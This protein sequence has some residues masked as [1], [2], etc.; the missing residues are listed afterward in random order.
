M[1][2]EVIKSLFRKLMLHMHTG[3]WLCSHVF[4]DHLMVGLQDGVPS[5]WTSG[6]QVSSVHIAIS[7][8]LL[9]PSTHTIAYFVT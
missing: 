2:H 9:K 1:L 3:E 7:L 8:S 5:S 4:H 6:L